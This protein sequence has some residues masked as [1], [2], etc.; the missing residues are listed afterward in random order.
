MANFH[1]PLAP[2]G[3]NDGDSWTN[4]TNGRTKFWRGG[5]WRSETYVAAGDTGLVAGGALGLQ[6]GQGT[7]GAPHIFF[8]SGAPSISANKGSLYLRSDGSSTSSRLYVN[9]DGASTWTAVTTAA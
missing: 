5:D 7:A 1:G 2:N 8:G 3:P 4:S 6:I 9:T